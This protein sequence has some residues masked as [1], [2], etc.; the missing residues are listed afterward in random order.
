MLSLW[1]LHYTRPHEHHPMTQRPPERLNLSQ[2]SGKEPALSATPVP[3]P[4]TT[5]IP[6]DNP[7]QQ[8]SLADLLPCNYPDLHN[9][10]GKLLHRERRSHTLSPTALVNEVFLRL[11][12]QRKTSWDNREGFLAAATGMMRR[13]LSNHGRDRNALKR[14]GK[15]PRVSL[16]DAPARA[17]HGGHTTKAVRIALETLRKRDPRAADIA[18]HRLY[19]GLGNDIIA[20]SLGISLRTVEREWAVARAWLR[21]ELAEEN[22]A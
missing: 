22:Q 7:T 20:E 5:T 9:T 6:S 15:Q 8:K 19:R 4:P 2:I 13:I 16:Q 3:S 18:E 12:R 14:G 11:A 21:A 17:V 10:A 1:I